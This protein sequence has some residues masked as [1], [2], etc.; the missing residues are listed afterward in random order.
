[1]SDDRTIL[2]CGQMVEIAFIYEIAIYVA[3]FKLCNVTLTPM[4]VGAVRA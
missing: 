1:M 3:R 4:F 2:P